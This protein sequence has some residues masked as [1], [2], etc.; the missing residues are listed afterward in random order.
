[1]PNRISP[2]MNGDEKLLLGAREQPI[3]YALIGQRLP[4][5]EPVLATI[6]AFNLEFLP[7]FDAILPSKLGR[8]HDLSLGGHGCLHRL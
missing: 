6:E 5:H 8:E 4:P 3:D 1:M 2:R 7:C